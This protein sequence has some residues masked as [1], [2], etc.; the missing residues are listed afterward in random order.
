MSSSYSVDETNASPRPASSTGGIKCGACSADN[1]AEGQFCASCGHGLYEPCVGCTKPVLLSQ[2]FCTQCGCDL[3][4]AVKKKKGELEEKIAVAV[5][6]TKERDFER[7]RGLLQVVSRESDFRFA[8]VVSHAKTALKKV[9]AIASQESQ[10]A[11]T[12]IAAAEQAHRNG[13]AARVVELLGGLAPKLLTD[14]AKLMLQ[15]ARTLLEQL[16]DSQSALEEAFQKRDWAT[17]GAILNR[18]L[19][20]KPDDESVDRL[21]KKVGKKLVSKAQL[22][23][24]THKYRA[25]ANLLDCVPSNARDEHYTELHDHIEAISWLSSQFTAEPFATPTLGRLA[26]KWVERSGGDPQGTA[27]LQRLGRRVKESKSSSRE[28]YPWFD[29]AVHS[30]IGGRVGVLAYPTSVAADQCAEAKTAPG[31][32]NVAIGLALQGLGL[33][34]ITDDFTSKKGLLS[35]LGKKKVA[36]C[37]GV[38]LGAS[39]LKAILLELDGEGRPKLS[40]CVY[41]PFDSTLTRSINETKAA[42]LVRGS[43]E[44][45]LAENEVGQDPIWVSFPAR[46]LVSRFVKLPPVADKQAK[47]LFEREIESRIP[48]PLDEVATVQW[49]APL[50]EDELIPIGRPAFVSAAKKQFVD[51]YLDQLQAAGLT[52]AGLQSTP[53]ALANFAWYEFADEVNLEGVDENTKEVSLPTI[54]LADCG[55]ETT[56]LL[57]VSNHSCWFWSFESGGEDFTRLIARAT[58]TTHSEAEK[59][60]RNPA[61]L[62]HPETQYETVEQKMEEMHGRISKLVSDTLNEHKEFDLRQTWCCGGG[63]RAHG[64]IRRVICKR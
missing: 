1:P 12:R 52:V 41:V 59:I 22:L 15:E 14:S 48:L 31:Q 29:S 16:G 62:E 30:W 64:W 26:Q 7:A 45:F 34:R 37:W 49:M 43:I 13:D 27:M 17:S 20:L 63:V 40:K 53:I 25:A 4:A 5:R 3:V 24:E 55:A 42:E 47:Q 54:A 57:F 9:D 51:R 28:L 6:A 32:Y 23:R 21:A 39:G 11:S 8:E 19:Q 58:Q 46:E 56:T 44:T 36:R 60:K 18:M 33:T 50:P 61:V 2:A 10:S 35:R 38:D